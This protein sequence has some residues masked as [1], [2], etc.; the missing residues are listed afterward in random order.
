[1]PPCGK[2]LVA[3]EKT[4]VHFFGGSD[5]QLGLPFL[6]T[7]DCVCAARRL[8]S[9]AMRFVHSFHEYNQEFSKC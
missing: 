8:F 4:S 5:G 6:P 2:G 3:Q 9:Y 1:M 7:T